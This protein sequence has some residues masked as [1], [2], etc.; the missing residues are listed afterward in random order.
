M[1]DEK[2]L[3]EEFEASRDLQIEFGDD[4]SAFFALAK[5]EDSVRKKNERR[6]RHRANRPRDI[7]VDEPMLRKEFS[8]SAALKSEFGNDVDLFLTFKRGE[9]KGMVKKFES[10]CVGS[11]PSPKAEETS[12][13]GQKKTE[14]KI[15]D[16]VL[17]TSEKV[18]DANAEAVR[19]AEEISRDEAR[20]YAAG[21][22]CTP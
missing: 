20:Q 19:R 7:E 9:G 15:P 5:H 10:N 4:F 18:R 2:K 21:T 16:K 3:R 17:H 22:V 6:A 14:K 8:A 11:Q 13:P 12:A 1:L